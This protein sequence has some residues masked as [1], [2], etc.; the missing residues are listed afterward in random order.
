MKPSYLCFEG[1]PNWPTWAVYL[2]LSCDG[3]AWAK[4]QA[5]ARRVREDAAERPGLPA[6]VA[7]R[8][9]LAARLRVAHVRDLQSHADLNAKLTLW[10]LDQVAWEELARAVLD[11]S[12][13]SG[14]EVPD[15]G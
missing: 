4:W 14:W 6:D 5:V 2:T 8:G 13:P 9:A 11:G 1:W 12:E 3:S 7:T 10:A 15:A